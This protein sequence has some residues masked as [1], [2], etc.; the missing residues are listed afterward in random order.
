MTD[1]W[2]NLDNNAHRGD[3]VI[4][5]SNTGLMKCKNGEIK[6]IPLRRAVYVRGKLILIYRIL[7][8]AF[9]PNP[10]NKPFVD[11]ITHDRTKI[12][13]P[14]NDIRNLRWCTCKENNNFNEGIENKRK[15]KLGTHH[16]LEH[17]K[18][19]SESMKGNPKL[20]VWKNKKRSDKTR[21]KMSESAK[22][23]WE[24]RRERKKAKDKP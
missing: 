14:L 23:G 15:A 6:E 9:I 1:I 11:H 18:H 20:A 17:N 5:V 4:A 8:E 2:I 10:D 7:A 3:T 22:I 24:K 16:T 21:K 13:Y 12:D 19:I